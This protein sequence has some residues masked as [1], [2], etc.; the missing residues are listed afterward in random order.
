[1]GAIAPGFA[2][3][4]ALAVV[5]CGDGGEGKSIFS[6]RFCAALGGPPTVEY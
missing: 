3:E 6:V 5:M 4:L 1:M 2:S